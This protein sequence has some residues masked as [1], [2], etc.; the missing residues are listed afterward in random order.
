MME[1]IQGWSLALLGNR[2]KNANLSFFLSKTAIIKSEDEAPSIS[3]PF[4]SNVKC[5][6]V[7]LEMFCFQIMTSYSLRLIPDFFVTSRETST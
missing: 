6:R 4:A 5:H 2:R 1:I 7:A 3:F